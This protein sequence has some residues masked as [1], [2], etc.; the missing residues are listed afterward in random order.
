M[1]A[2]EHV[3][4]RGL[5]YAI[6]PN[7]KS[8]VGLKNILIAKLDALDGNDGSALFSAV[9]G[10][11]K[12]DPEGYPYVFVLERVGKGNIIDTA[13]NQ[14][15]WQFSV[16]IHYPV[17]GTAAP[18]EAEES[19]IAM[20]DAVDRVIKSFDEDPMLLD[21]HGEAQCAKCEVLPVEFEFAR[22]ETPLHRAL[23]TVA[24]VDLVRRY[25]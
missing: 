13:R 14:R 22:Q 25:P 1:P 17:T 8:Y 12:T 23:L 2:T 10:I 24:I 21:V 6:R 19:Y 11:N 5:T 16:I 18:D 20:L 15:E 3:I 4:T 9:Y 7:T